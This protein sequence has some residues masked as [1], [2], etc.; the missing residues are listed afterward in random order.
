MSLLFRTEARAKKHPRVLTALKKLS[1][2]DWRVVVNESAQRLNGIT[3]TLLPKRLDRIVAALVKLDQKTWRDVVSVSVWPAGYAESWEEDAIERQRQ[4][5]RVGKGKGNRG[6]GASATHRMLW[7]GTTWDEALKLVDSLVAVDLHAAVDL[8]RAQEYAEWRAISED[9]TPVVMRLRVPVSSA[10]PDTVAAHARAAA[11]LRGHAGQWVIN[12]PFTLYETLVWDYDNDEWRAPDDEESEKAI[13]RQR[14]AQRA[15]GRGN[16]NRGR[17]RGSSIFVQRSNVPIRKAKDIAE[18]NNTDG[19]GTHEVWERMDAWVA[20]QGIPAVLEAVKS[21][22]K[23][24]GAAWST[25]EE[26]WWIS[27]LSP[28][29][30]QPKGRARR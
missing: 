18:I 10:R 3:T 1:K 12:G 6:R 4:A 23:S 17:G 16:G 2:D 19:S 28:E 27:Q 14:Q 13:E 15:K 20:A 22:Y 7:H 9:D 21:V 8:G 29:T 5:Q 24:N 25:G 26:N 11:G 30:T